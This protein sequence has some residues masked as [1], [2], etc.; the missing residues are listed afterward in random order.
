MGHA[1]STTFATLLQSIPRGEIPT[2]LYQ[3]IEA[4]HSE[5]YRNLP[6]KGREEVEIGGWEIIID[7]LGN[8]FFLRFSTTEIVLSKGL[9]LLI[10]TS[11]M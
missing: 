3:L 11:G 5:N 4:I 6:G 7:I 9:A 10:K 1:G 2:L 8:C